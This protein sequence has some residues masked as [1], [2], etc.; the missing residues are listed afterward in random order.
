MV[1]MFFMGSAVCP[2]KESV[3]AHDEQEEAE[4][5][6][7]VDENP[8][9]D[10]STY[11]TNGM[12]IIRYAALCNYTNFLCHV[13][14]TQGAVSRY[15]PGENEPSPLELAMEFN[16]QE[17][18]DYL[19]SIRH[20][21]VL[22]RLNGPSLISVAIMNDNVL[23][24]EKFLDI[25]VDVNAY[26]GVMGFPW[27]DMACKGSIGMYELLRSRGARFGGKRPLSVGRR[28]ELLAKYSDEML[29]L[30]TN[31]LVLPSGSSID[32]VLNADGVSVTDSTLA[33]IDEAISTVG[34]RCNGT[35]LMVVHTPSAVPVH[36]RM[37]EIVDR[38]N[39]AVVRIPEGM[40]SAPENWPMEFLP[41]IPANDE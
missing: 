33:E 30:Y 39:V 10:I 13:E 26:R 27:M 3:Y 34:S 23:Q 36:I 40:E 8:G 12:R 37:D 7:F 15:T 16:L 38:I 6:Q 28:Q 14:A 20:D 31:A 2:G 5:I 21:W 4:L 32:F 24:T 41:Y 11:I 22:E 9:V 29:H 1:Q 19:A 25:G 35:A 17:A 18:T